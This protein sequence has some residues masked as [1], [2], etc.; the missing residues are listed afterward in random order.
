MSYTSKLYQYA[1]RAA[2]L[3][4]K[5]RR[6]IRDLLA[7]VFVT[8]CKPG[9]LVSKYPAAR[10]VL[11]STGYQ[12]GSHTAEVDPTCLTDWDIPNHPFA[13]LNAVLIARGYCRQERRRRG[14]PQKWVDYVNEHGGEITIHNVSDGVYLSG[15]FPQRD[16]DIAKGYAAQVECG[17]YDRWSEVIEEAVA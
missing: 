10:A 6:R 16:L 15:K 1:P 11:Y 5:Q 7:F 13:N 17:L 3:T 4:A 9:G 2:E 8:G 14:R 12:R